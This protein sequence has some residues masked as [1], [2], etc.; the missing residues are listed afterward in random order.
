VNRGPKRAILSAVSLPTARIPRRLGN[1]DYR[2]LLKILINFRY[3][4]FLGLF[5][6][7]PPEIQIEIISRLSIPKLLSLRLASKGLY[8]L[9][10][11]NESQIARYHIANTLPRYAVD[12]YPPPEAEKA[13]FYYLFAIWHRLHVASKYSELVTEQATKEIFLRTTEQQR[14]EFKPQENR[15]RRNLM[16]RIFTINHFFE[17]YRELHVGAIVSSGVPLSR[18]AITRNPFESVIF[19]SYSDDTLLKAHEAWPLVISSF[20][21]RLRPPSYAGRIEKSIKGHYW[22]E[23]PADEV[24]AAILYV[25]GLRQAC[26]FWNI[27]GYD[28]RRKAVDTWYNLLTESSAKSAA[29]PQ[30]SKRGLLSLSRLGGKNT[31]G[32]L[33][34]QSNSTGD[35]KQCCGQWYCVKPDCTPHNSAHDPIP[36]TTLSAGPP[37]SPLTKT[38]L[39]LFLPDLPHLSNIWIHTAEAVILDRGIMEK[40]QYIKRNTQVLLDLIRDD[41]ADLGD[42]WE[43]ILMDQ[44]VDA[45]LSR[46][47]WRSRERPTA[48][49]PPSAQEQSGEAAISEFIP[50]VESTTSA[51]SG[52]RPEDMKPEDPHIKCIHTIEL[53]RSVQRTEQP[54]SMPTRETTASI[55]PELSISEPP[56]VTS[57][58]EETVLVPKPPSPLAETTFGDLTDPTKSETTFNVVA[59]TTIA[60]NTSPEDAAFIYPQI[61]N[62]GLMLMSL[63]SIF[64]TTR[65]VFFSCLYFLQQALGSFSE[66]WSQI[67]GLETELPEGMSRVRWKCVSISYLQ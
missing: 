11:S 15:M 34:G 5:F 40:P 51:D 49:E 2:T 4:S 31:P 66:A 54:S 53:G 41:G 9:V 30:K 19:E 42:N 67:L 12:L 35:E 24:Y 17:R 43:N 26:G 50:N 33:A 59:S 1:C 48:E 64:N 3:E 37:M 47:E 57:E 44:T 39:E 21:R 63:K 22:K 55:E 28:A 45:P 56:K 32:S 29:K 6:G 46:D 20:S 61:S 60:T 52:L 18:Q 25:G 7:L 62:S 58:T 14:Q 38:E 23:K 16:L 8:N 36:N 65:D 27:K 10:A 13:R